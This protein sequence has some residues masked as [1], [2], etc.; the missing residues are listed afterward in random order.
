MKRCPKCLEEK[1]RADFNSSNS[2]CRLCHN[3]MNRLWREENKEINAESQ[4]KYAEK[5]DRACAKKYAKA[6]Y[7]AN[8]EVYLARNKARRLAAARYI[9]SIKKTCCCSV[10]GITDYRCLDFHHVDKSSKEVIISEMAS[11]GDTEKRINAELEKCVPICRNCH[12][13]EHWSEVSDA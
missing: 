4:R 12:A 8:K 11:R 2:Y 9:L 7:A 5:T 13:I 3:A 10:C 1:N 6:H